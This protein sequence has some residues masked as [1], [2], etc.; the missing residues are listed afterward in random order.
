MTPLSYDVL[1]AV[2]GTILILALALAPHVGVARLLGS[3]ILV[4][5]GELSFA[6]Y[7]VHWPIG[8][9][10]IGGPL[11][12]GISLSSSATLALGLFLLVALSWGLHVIFER[13]ARVWLRG[14]FLSSGAASL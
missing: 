3:V 6:F 10:V 11:A 1:Y 9:L 13:P 7:L 4:A 2:P 14:K 5:L 12:G 8:G